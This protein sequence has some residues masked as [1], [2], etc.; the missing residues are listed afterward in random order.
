M[1]H[2]AMI[3]AIDPNLVLDDIPYV[4]RINMW[5]QNVV[6]TFGK[7]MSEINYLEWA[8]K[9]PIDAQHIGDLALQDIIACRIF[10]CNIHAMM[11]TH[12][13]YRRV[14]YD[15]LGAAFAM[16]ELSEEHPSDYNSRYER[17]KGD[18]VLY[19]DCYNIHLRNAKREDN[20]LNEICTVR[21]ADIGRRN[22]GR[23]NFKLETCCS[24]ERFKSRAESQMEYK[25]RPEWDP[26]PSPITWDL[27][28]TRDPPFTLSEGGKGRADD[29]LRPLDPA[30]LPIRK[31]GQD[32]LPEVKLPHPTT[33]VKAPLSRAELGI[34]DEEEILKSFTVSQLESH[35]AKLQAEQ[36]STLTGK[37]PLILTPT[38]PP[39]PL[40]PVDSNNETKLRAS[41]KIKLLKLEPTEIT[42]WGKE[43]K[44]FESKGYGHWN[45]EQID[46]KIK[47]LIDR[48][49]TDPYL[50]KA[51]LPLRVQESRDSGHI[52]D[53]NEWKD[54]VYISTDELELFLINTY[55]RHHG[56][57][58]DDKTHNT[59]LSFIEKYQLR[60]TEK[61]G[62][63]E[64]EMF[65][66]EVSLK[67]KQ[68]LQT[69]TSF[70]K[71][72]EKEICKAIRRL[73]EDALDKLST[74][75]GVF[76]RR[77]VRNL[78]KAEDT[79]K[80]IEA[81]LNAVRTSFT[82]I[83]T[84]IKGKEWLQCS[85]SDSSADERHKRRRQRHSDRDYRSDK[86]YR[87]DRK[88]KPD[89][90]SSNKRKDSSA[91]EPGSPNHPQK[92]KHTGKEEKCPGCGRFVNE[93]HTVKTC[94]YIL[95]KM[96]G[97][98]PEWE[99]K[100]FA[101]S[102]AGKK[103]LAETGRD[104]LLSPER[105]ENRTGGGAR[106]G[107]GGRGGGNRNKNY[108]GPGKPSGSKDSRGPGPNRKQS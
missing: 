19:W 86:D 51:G 84:E 48:R 50:Y 60:I 106:H 53:P 92:K 9:V 104:F 27:A 30:V 4:Q 52:P 90:Q 45:R 96:K 108:Y 58:F 15:I 43:A 2:V 70:D 66:L 102:E 71:E 28:N 81:A 72:Q 85:D 42:K 61:N 44:D 64:L 94:K 31:K 38:P 13:K 23:V 10:F 82:S 87:R 25:Y 21:F 26:L 1:E 105:L 83:I 73:V 36:S 24:D 20:L 7:A 99:S 62:Y 59:L 35:L 107:G 33:P 57:V 89:E 55:Q 46:A 98:N 37:S 100:A 39:P 67:Y 74:T 18:D 17:N 14:F 78:F 103:C 29:S 95:D 32:P 6:R 68:V 40:P 8:T 5:G 3:L 34:G 69:I 97:Y 77:L 63:E 56:Q 79:K 22:K 54:P 41:E 80:S 76:A 93:H 65:E 12:P 47:L 91:N 88:A 49:W 11:E 16:N 101:D 75:E